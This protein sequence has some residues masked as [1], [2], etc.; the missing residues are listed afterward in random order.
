MVLIVALNECDRKIYNIM[1]RYLI[2][3]ESEVRDRGEPMNYMCNNSKSHIILT[4]NNIPVGYIESTIKDKKYYIV[5]IIEIFPMFRGNSYARDTILELEKQGNNVI[6][7]HPLSFPQWINVMGIIYWRN[8]VMRLGSR[9]LIELMSYSSNGNYT[10]DKYLSKFLRRLAFD[11]DV[12]WNTWEEYINLIL[13]DPTIILHEPDISM[14]P[15][16]Y[17]ATREDG[18]V[19]CKI[20]YNSVS[21][22]L[23][24]REIFILDTMDIQYEYEK[25]PS[26]FD[27]G[28]VLLIDYLASLGLSTRHVLSNK[29]LLIGKNMIC[30]DGSILYWD[31]L[32]S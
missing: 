28:D 20:M 5:E 16:E 18:S 13:L 23:T 26:I 2:S 12:S 24:S 8:K 22:Q 11:S 1:V 27:H 14:V 4:D 30:S 29:H 25:V 6:I 3:S 32:L 7:S 15:Y 19:M 9:L 10:E 21:R 31:E 17:Y